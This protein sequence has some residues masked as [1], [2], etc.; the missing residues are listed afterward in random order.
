MGRLGRS[1]QDN[2]VDGVRRGARGISFAFAA[3]VLAGCS[4]FGQSLGFDPLLGGPP[5]RPAMAGTPPAAAP[6]PLPLPAAN[7]SLSAA[8]LAAGTPRPLDSGQDLRIGAPIASA[9]NDG[10]TRQG[11]NNPDGSGVTLQPPQPISEAPPKRDLVAVSNPGL[12][13]DPPRASPSAPSGIT[14]LEQAQKEL[15]ARGVLWQNLVRVGPNGEW[16]FSCSMPNR[17]NPRQQRTYEFRANEPIA[18]IR[19]V[20]GQ[21]DKDSSLP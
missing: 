10:W 2:T 16:K 8:A 3:M 14:T 1:D 7:S 21:I 5:L 12:A 11:G 20:L 13:R 15:D 18:A 4:D 17:Q 6:T 9:G 19:A